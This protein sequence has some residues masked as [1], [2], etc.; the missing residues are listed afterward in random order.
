M[1]QNSITPEQK[2]QTVNLGGMMTHVEKVMQRFNGEVVGIP[3]KSEAVYY[4]QPEADAHNALLDGAIGPEDPLTAE[5]AEA[6]NTAT[7]GAEKAAGDTLTAEEASAYNATLDGAVTTA[8]VKTPA[9]PQK[10]K[11][12]VD[13]NT[14]GDVTFD[15]ST[16]ELRR[17]KNGISAKV[18]DIVTSGFNIT[19]DDTNGIDVITAVGSATVTEDDTNGIDNF[20]F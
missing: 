4:T 17:T 18:C 20:N 12:Y 11:E 3:N 14:V 10:V 2:G 6:Y 1:P 8:D 16:G 15:P 5:Q 9:V 13:G 19:Q 7:P